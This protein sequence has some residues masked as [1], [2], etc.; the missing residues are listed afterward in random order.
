MEVQAVGPGQSARRREDVTSAD[1]A[2]VGGEEFGPNVAVDD[3]D[4][5]VSKDGREAYSV[6]G[7]DGS[8]GLCGQLV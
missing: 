3:G 4:H 6:A 2:V 5:D 7:L 8:D 1:A